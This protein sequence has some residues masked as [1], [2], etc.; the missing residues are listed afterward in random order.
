M[1]PTQLEAFGQALTAT[2]HRNVTV[3][4]PEQYFCDTEV[5]GRCVNATGYATY[6]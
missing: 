5:K 6:Y 2:P 3:L 1:L 4:R